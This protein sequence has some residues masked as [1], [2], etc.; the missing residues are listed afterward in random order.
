MS[1]VLMKPQSESKSIVIFLIGTTAS[2]EIDSKL[3]TKNRNT[4][5]HFMLTVHNFFTQG[6]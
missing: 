4:N 1:G 2:N 3:L 6:K 5:H